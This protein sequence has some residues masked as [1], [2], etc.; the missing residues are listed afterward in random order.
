MIDV[1]FVL[2]GSSSV[3]SSQFARMLGWVNKVARGLDRRFHS[4]LR[5]GIVQFG[6]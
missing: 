5:V 1:M 6:T 4:K 2:D 3:S